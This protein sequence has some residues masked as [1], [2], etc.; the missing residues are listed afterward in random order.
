[1]TYEGDSRPSLSSKR[2]SHQVSQPE[3]LSCLTP[4]NIYIL[5]HEVY[6]AH[7]FVAPTGTSGGHSVT[8]RRAPEKHELTHGSK[9]FPN[10][11]GPFGIVPNPYIFPF[12]CA[13]D[14]VFLGE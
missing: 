5:Q 7:T 1:M 4:K 2:A 14:L 11:N 8:E 9:S 12:H 3:R 6:T 10:K 13:P